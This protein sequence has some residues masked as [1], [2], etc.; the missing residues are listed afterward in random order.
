MSI[1]DDLC[2]FFHIG[3]LVYFRSSMPLT[4][5]EIECKSMILLDIEARDK[6]CRVKFYD[7]E[8]GGI[9]TLCISP[10]SSNKKIFH[11]KSTNEITL[12][13][14]VGLWWGTANTVIRIQKLDG[15]TGDKKKC[16]TEKG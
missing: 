8:E 15:V 6:L 3:D 14:Y 5:C 1:Y 10:F 7:I 2:S 4:L 13:A 9:K 12:E 11:I 16:L